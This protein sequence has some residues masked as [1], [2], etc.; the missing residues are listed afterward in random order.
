[1]RRRNGSARRKQ[2]WT[3]QDFAAA[4]G[5]MLGVEKNAVPP[6]V[7]VVGQEPKDFPKTEGYWCKYRGHDYHL[8]TE[9]AHQFWYRYKIEGE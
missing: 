3:R 4:L 6:R 8:N 1:M 7:I 5:T 9:T 2:G